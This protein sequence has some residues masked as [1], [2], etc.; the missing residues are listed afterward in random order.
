MRNGDG[1]MDD[2]LRAMSRFGAV[3]KVDGRTASRKTGDTLR[4]TIRHMYQ[5]RGPLCSYRCPLETALPQP[6]ACPV[7]FRLAMAYSS[8]A[9][10]PRQILSAPSCKSIR[11]AKMSCRA[12]S[13]TPVLRVHDHAKLSA[14]Q[15]EDLMLRPR[16]DFSSILDTVRPWTHSGKG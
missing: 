1:W 12:V 7:R 10:A 6:S 16:I 3:E 5:N 4:G 2:T 14:K 15:L 8:C 9:G 13:Q 11:T